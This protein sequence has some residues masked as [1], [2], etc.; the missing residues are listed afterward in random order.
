MGKPCPGMQEPPACS[1]CH[2]IVL[3]STALPGPA[4]LEAGL[5]LLGHLAESVTTDLSSSRSQLLKIPSR[6]AAKW[7]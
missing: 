1:V 2:M 3:V 6:S 5:A 7:K 4:G